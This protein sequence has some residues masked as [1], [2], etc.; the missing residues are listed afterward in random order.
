MARFIELLTSDYYDMRTS[1]NLDHVAEIYHN[2]HGLT[3]KLADGRTFNGKIEG[4][5][6]LVR[7]GLNSPQLM[8]ATAGYVKITAVRRA[9][10]KVIR[11]YGHPVVGWAVNGGAVWRATP[12]T[13][14]GDVCA[15]EPEEFQTEAV[16]DPAGQVVDGSGDT[17]PDWDAFV[18][19]RYAETLAEG[20]SLQ[21]YGSAPRPSTPAVKAAVYAPPPSPAGRPLR[22]SSVKGF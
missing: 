18:A 7:Q 11:L 10:E 6:D 9:D 16:I 13:W 2:R 21:F 17:Y 8:P 22:S 20:W 19:A 14:E 3:V 1:I 15:G 4:D 5:P 12:V